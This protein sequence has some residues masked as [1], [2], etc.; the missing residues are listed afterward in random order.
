MGYRILIAVLSVAGLVLL[1]GFQLRLTSKLGRRE[2]EAMH[3]DADVEKGR[4]V[5]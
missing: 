4:D 2:D 1:F 3:R 5:T